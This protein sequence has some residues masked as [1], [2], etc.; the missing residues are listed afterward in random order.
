MCDKIYKAGVY[1]VTVCSGS[2]QSYRENI[3]KNALSVILVGLF[4]IAA[5]NA[6]PLSADSPRA[7]AFTV[8]KDYIASKITS[9]GDAQF[10]RYT[11]GGLSSRKPNLFQVL[12]PKVVLRGPYEISTTDQLNGLEWQGGMTLNFKAIRPLIEHEPVDCSGPE[13]AELREE[14]EKKPKWQWGEWVERPAGISIV[15]EKRNG[16]WNNQP[17]LEGLF[18]EPISCEEIPLMPPPVKTKFTPA[19]PATPAPKK[20]SSAPMVPFKI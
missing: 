11:W 5:A 10:Y 13:C 12:E 6:A 15:Y 16:Q 14:H 9:C 3:M 8:G 18:G 1:D 2:I 20:G 17:A 4:S 7:E 19:T